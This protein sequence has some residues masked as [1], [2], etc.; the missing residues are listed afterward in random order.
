[1]YIQEIN[2]YCFVDGET[3]AS[4]STTF[5]DVLTIFSLNF[6]PVGKGP[7]ILW[8]VRQKIFTRGALSRGEGGIGVRDIAPPSLGNLGTK[9]SEM[10]FPHFKTYF[11]QIGHCYLKTII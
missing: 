8:L 4:I 3:I 5:L 6:S 9:F 11:T 2:Y 10:S 1:M 7:L